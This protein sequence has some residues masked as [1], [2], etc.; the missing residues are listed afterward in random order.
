[1]L[2]KT[3]LVIFPVLLLSLTLPAHTLQKETRIFT[4]IEG[5]ALK[6]DIYKTDSAT[7]LP[8]PCL[9]FVFGG[10]F[11]EGKRDSGSYLPYFHYFANKGFTVVSVDYRLGMKG[12]DAPGIMN[13]KPLQRSIE[14]AV[15]DLYTATNYLLKNAGELDID[16]SLF[17]LSGSSAGAI[18]VLQ[19]DYMERDNY[20]AADVLPE[21][22]RYAGVISFA[23]GIFSTEGAPSYTQRPAPTLFFHGSADKLVPFNSTRLFNVGMFGSRSL[24]KRF[25]EERYPYTFYIMEDVGHEVSDYPMRE[26]LP[27][28]EQFITDFVFDRKQWMRD[29]RFKDLQRKSDTSTTPGNYYN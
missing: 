16:P 28:I 1:M 15:S 5:V 17:I 2:R 22:F 27:E 14:M 4:E 29:I 8:Q 9:I 25:R 6:L 13:Y 20:P 10:G 12:K 23:G 21:D 11:K 18:T 24:A 19:A 7:I 26:F 3:V